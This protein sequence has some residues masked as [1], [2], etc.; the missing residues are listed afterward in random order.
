VARVAATAMVAA[1][2]TLTA[3][4]PPAS[5]AG[6]SSATGVT[7]VVEFNQLGGGAQVK[8]DRSGG[9]DSAASLFTSNG[10]RLEYA[11]RQPGFVCRVS[12]VPAS[13]PCI[14]TSPSDAYWSLYWSDGQSGRWAY[15]STSAGSLT[16][17]DG[18][19]VAFTWKQGAAA[20]PP[21]TSAT[22]HEQPPPPSAQPTKAPS[23]APPTP[24]PSPSESESPSE[25]ATPSQPAAP[26]K[27]DKKKPKKTPKPS[28][29]TTASSTPS[30]TVET[31][32]DISPTASPP[33]AGDDGLP[34]WVAPGLIVLL[35]VA[36]GVT[37]V[38]RRRG[39]AGS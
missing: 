38:V 35:F 1:A 4:L 5:A 2:A 3:P 17:P 11:K 18:G 33:D 12:G 32:D 9:G 15:S 25:S 10:F 8:C 23:A 6:C 22:P 29:A 30:P 31:G 16:I 7:V 19:Y 20:A 37:V 39:A 21:R 36:A 28:D 26:A 34:V 14:D 27:P 24:S 13:D